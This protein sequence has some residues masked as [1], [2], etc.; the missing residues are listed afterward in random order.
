MSDRKLKVGFILAQSFTLSA[1]ALFV[2]HCTP[3]Q[4]TPLIDLA[5]YMLIGKF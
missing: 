2:D 3:L 4:V 5:G 1:F